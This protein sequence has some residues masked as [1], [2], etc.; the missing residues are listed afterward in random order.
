MNNTNRPLL[1]RRSFA[2]EH[3][4]INDTENALNVG[5][6]SK[7]ID[8][9][10]ISSKLMRAGE[11]KKCNFSI[12]WVVDNLIPE[13]AII[14][15][16]AQAG[17]GKSTISSQIAAAVTKG[18]PVFGMN[19]LQRHVIILDFENPASVIKNRLNLIDD[20][21]DIIFWPS[22]KKPPRL[23]SPE[24]SQLIRL[25][26]LYPNPV[27]II[28][29][30]G[31]ATPNCDI[32]SNKDYS[33]VMKQFVEI[34][35][36]G[37]TIILLHHTSKADPS[38]YIGA[39]TIV[40][41]C[42]H[43]LALWPSNSASKCSDTENRS[44]RVFRFGTGQK[45]RF[46]HYELYVVFDE[47]TCSFVI[48]DDPEKYMFQQLK[49]ILVENGPLNQTQIID[50]VKGTAL[51]KHARQVLKKGIGYLWDEKKGPHNARIYQLI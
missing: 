44:D 28:D 21:D 17:S 15:F 43:V 9:N 20:S 39:S 1:N 36:L 31:G 4:K 14:L 35:D 8:R 25:V 11:I 38:K 41:Q 47:D 13:H 12:N 23:D 7:N 42:D 40:N 50:L 18:K 32:S 29:T 2:V 34:R 26:E 37:A 19:T 33:N 5:T 46:G 3:S 6:E 10:Y 49:E 45:T 22:F 30:L 27:L 51:E 48:A 16:Y 24:W